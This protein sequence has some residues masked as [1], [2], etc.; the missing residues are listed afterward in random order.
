MNQATRWARVLAGDAASNGR[1]FTGGFTPGS[2]SR[3][4]DQT[5]QLKPENVR[6]FPSCSAARESGL[7]ACKLDRPDDFAHGADPVLA[8]SESLVSEIRANP[9][10]FTDARAL[11]HHWPTSRPARPPHRYPPPNFPPP[12]CACLTHSRRSRP[13]NFG[14]A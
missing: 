1:F 13:G 10:A 12:H 5:R 14:D 8:T 3:P 11:V 7:R 2:A 6:F 4:S 9:A